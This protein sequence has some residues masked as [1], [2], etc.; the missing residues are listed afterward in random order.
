MKI[1]RLK[2]AITLFIGCIGIVNKSFTQQLTS[3]TAANIIKANA[4]TI[5]LSK[6]DLDNMRISGAY[7]DKIS[8]AYLIYVQQTY[9]SADV[10]NAIQ[11]YAFK[12]GKLI[13]ATGKPMAEIANMINAK[14]GK[15]KVTPANAVSAAA[16]QL[17]LFIT[18]SL[19]A[20]KQLNAMQEFDFGTLNISSVNVKS[21]LIWLPDELT[22]KA[23]LTWQVEIQPKGSPD[24]WL[25]NV[26]ALNGNVIN[27]INLNI[28]CDWTH[29]NNAGKIGTQFNT[30]DYT[31]LNNAEDA[32][33]VNGA[34]YKVVPF[35]KESPD[36]GA[37]VLKQDPWTLAGTGNNA[38][39]LKWNSDGTVDF[40]STRGNN[41]LAQEDVNGNNGLGNGANSTTA[42]PN[43][44]FNFTPNFGSAPT[45]TANQNFAVTNLFY[46]NNIMHDIS[47]QYGFDEVS[48]NFQANNLG[49]GGAG[50]DYVFA[51]AQDGSSSNNANFSTPADGNS[52]RMQM[53]LFDAV[54]KFTVNKPTSFAGKKS[55]T[56]SA[57]STNN[58][59]AD[60]GPITKAVVLYNDDASGTTHEGCAAPANAGALAGKIALIDRGTCGFTVKVKNAEIAGAIGAVIADNIPGEYPIIMG[61][62]D[63]TITIPA[64]LVSF[65][66]GDTMKQFLAT[67][68]PVNVTMKKGMQ[69][70][71]DADDGVIS[72]EF[73]HG[74]SN[75]LTGGPANVTCL[76]NK[77]E[78][79]EG[80]SDY[81]ALMVTTNWQNA[82]VNDGPNARPLGTYVLGQGVDGPGIRAY[83]YSID[84]SVNP[85]TYD[86][87]KLS[88]RF[89]NSILAF[90]PHVVGEV[91]CNMLWL[92]TWEII[93]SKGI[94]TNVYNA[95]AVKG[96]AIALKLV[97]EGM[98]LQKCSPGFVDGRDGILK[99]DTVLFGGQY[100]PI[101]WQAF[102]SRGL[103][104]NASEGSTNNV[105]D[106]VADY[107]LPPGL[108]VAKATQAED[109]IVH[110]TQVIT[111]AP[112]PA[113]NKVTLTINGNK[114]LLNIDL[115][116][117]NGQ[118]LKHFSMNSET[119]Q[120]NLPKLA[121]GMYYF[122]ISGEGF[123]E[124]KKLV[125]Q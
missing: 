71:G 35:P 36:V 52:P 105:K 63:N 85:W 90:D 25:V 45:T 28:V 65:E 61:G 55:S 67:S 91:W 102:A 70:D 92:M 112:N 39:T 100:S 12:N 80:W 56:E 116:N 7:I 57:F 47:Y 95:S 109:A 11:T 119:L 98:K 48:G 20:A 110:N 8:G 83:R 31:S 81:M 46:W 122:S 78:M 58:K 107:S 16:A 124:T 54:P 97:L 49:R 72:H 41:V 22:R 89:S 121:S 104:Y 103:G 106:G 21:K 2:I 88:K 38:T 6:T 115:L 79:G 77:E 51:D 29:P 96:N 9:K 33:A 120:I 34:K 44:T 123:A 59:I 93:Q 73:T 15:A 24:Y 99:A 53:F 32:L 27:K 94:A 14:D 117:A 37:P 5:G 60:K 125:I 17:K 75:R 3:Q 18:T 23:L 74:I 69:L 30:T 84:M 118:Q 43:L 62:T 86:S 13:S 1:L 4:S 76:Q 82:T 113:A 64:V 19:T 40:D 50:N 26:D 66:T 111:I 108:L 87:L 101:I 42:L 10:F 114:K 68:T